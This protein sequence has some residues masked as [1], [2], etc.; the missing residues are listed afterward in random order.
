MC[1]AWVAMVS[2]MCLCSVLFRG[3]GGRSRNN[4]VYVCPG[5]ILRERCV[6][7]GLVRCRHGC[8][9]LSALAMNC[10]PVIFMCAS[11]RSVFDSWCRCGIGV[12]EVHP[13]I[14]RSAL[15]CIVCSV[16]MWVLAKLQCQAGEAYVRVGRI[17]CLNSV[18]RF[19]F[20]H[21]SSVAA[22]AF[23][24]FSFFRALFLTVSVWCL[25]VMPGSKVSPRIF[26]CLFRGKV[27]PNRDT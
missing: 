19:S 23:M 4:C 18:V 15:F 9:G 13:V 25:K 2:C 21:P 6:G 11:M 27:S 3:V 14:S 16:W 5:I 12:E 7:I 22:S 10:V 1:I 17:V 20:E 26:G 24:T 8:I